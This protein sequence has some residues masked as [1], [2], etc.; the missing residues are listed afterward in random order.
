MTDCSNPANWL[1]LTR[2]EVLVIRD[3]T[4]ICPKA[5]SHIE[6]WPTVGEVAGSRE[7]LDVWRMLI[8]TGYIKE[9]HG[10][11]ICDVWDMRDLEDRANELLMSETDYERMRRTAPQT[12]QDNPPK[13]PTLLTDTIH[14]AT[15]TEWL[16]GSESLAEPVAID[17]ETE[18]VSEE[19]AALPPKMILGV[20]YGQGRGYYISP[21]HMADFI[22][23]HHTKLMVFH[24][25]VFDLEVI[26]QATDLDT[27]WLV[28]RNKVADTFIFERLLSLA[29]TGISEK[30]PT[31]QELTQRYAGI[32]LNKDEDI[33]TGFGQYAGESISTI[34]IPSRVY[35]AADAIATHKVYEKQLE[36]LPDIRRACCS[37]YGYPGEDIITEAWDTYGPLTLFT[38]VKASILASYMTRTGIGSATDRAEELIEKLNQQITEAG[39]L[40]R[41]SGIPTVLPGET[42][43]R[44]Q[45]K[46]KTAFLDYIK[47]QEDT[48]LE[49]ELIGEELP[50]TDTGKIKSDK[51]ARLDWPADPVIEAFAK[52]EVAKKLRNTYATKLTKP[53]LHPKWNPLLCTGRWSCT[54]D[55][56]IQTIPKGSDL[57]ACIV[58]P[59]GHHFVAVDYSTLE[60][61]ALAAA[62]EVMGYGST[63]ADIIRDGAD[64]HSLVA[65]K[66]L[67]IEPEA[68]TK[69]QRKS[70]KPITFGRPG[71]MGAK[72]ITKV[73]RLNY[74]LSMSEA[75]AE[76]I[77]RGYHK[78]CP[79]LDK[80]MQS[81]GPNPGEATAQALGLDHSGH[82]WDVL[83]VLKC[84]QCQGLE[85][86]EAW[87]AAKQLRP[88]IRGTA[89][90]RKRFTEDID[91]RKPS[92]HLEA[93]IRRAI[94]EESTITITGRI[95]ARCS[96]T[97]S[98]NA[99][100]QGLAADGAI[101]ALWKLWRE[102]Y[103]V[104]LFVHD[105]IVASVPTSED[106]DA[107]LRTISRIMEDTMTH[108][109]H[110]LPVKTE[111]YFSTSFKE[112]TEN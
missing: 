53:T 12:Q 46:T 38:Q 76:G 95:R 69:D 17:T 58:P 93:T 112:P 86:D 50:R 71:G 64:V 57:R 70:A 96:F 14:G 18:I 88:Y 36:R 85:A 19:P 37:A 59:P 54:G 63:L 67:G 78:L 49:E 30:Y 68:V 27:A 4:K 52:F 39:Q 47:Q 89:K 107:H 65:A 81:R 42:E 83:N 26:E 20:A 87:Q 6:R 101:L 1:K 22:Q 51:E 10:R 105:E 104:S 24:N 75:E 98:R 79:E 72:T 21:Q 9:H 2:E 8:G 3:F 109:L 91:H 31:L 56:A 90:E 61:V 102:G 16:P 74:G 55:I 99:I 62:F 106:L 60:V 108:V 29:T 41:A 32:E 43:P 40:L 103:R 44:G 82:G 23:A 5:R 33:R 66:A 94:T 34:P 25:A 110:G 73:A 7:S 80:H 48:W 13:Q 92:P 111:G 11:L 97:A 28:D 15:F 77:I 100:F 35:A 45:K 84:G